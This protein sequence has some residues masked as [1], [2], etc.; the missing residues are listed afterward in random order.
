M[1][2]SARYKRIFET[3]YVDLY[4][5][6]VTELFDIITSYFVNVISDQFD[7]EEEG[8]FFCIDDTKLNHIVKS[9]FY[10]IIRYKEFHFSEEGVSTEEEIHCI[11]ENGGKYI[12]AA[13]QAA[14][15]VKWILKVKPISID[16]DN[17]DELSEAQINICIT[18]NEF[19]SYMYANA[20][21]KIEFDDV[22]AEDIVYQ[23]HYRPYEEGAF[24][25]IFLLWD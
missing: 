5:E 16:K 14:Y 20:I 8:C 25:R 7:F 17:V 6:R 2:I 21:L 23:F 11:K 15:M 12:D 4:Q 13:K 19:L 18:L 24:E 9:Y 10:D 22:R 3:Y 1:N